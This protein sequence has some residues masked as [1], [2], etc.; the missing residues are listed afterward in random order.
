MQPS[1]KFGFVRL[2]EHGHAVHAAVQEQ[3]VFVER[4]G[5]DLHAD[6]GEA[7]L[8]APGHAG[9]VLRRSQRRGVAREQQD[10]A[11]AAVRQ[12]EGLRCGLLDGEMPALCVL[13]ALNPQ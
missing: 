13:S 8:D 5:I 4:E 3:P 7:R 12:R 6:G 10:V 9:D 11:D 2:L 1:V